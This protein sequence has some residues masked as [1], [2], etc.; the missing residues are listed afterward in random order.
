MPTLTYF[1]DEKITFPDK[2]VSVVEKKFKGKVHKAELDKSEVK[3]GAVK[4]QQAAQQRI[5]KQ[6]I[7][8][9]GFTSD[10][11]KQ[12]KSGGE[13]DGKLTKAG[14][15]DFFFNVNGKR[16]KATLE[17]ILPEAE[18]EKKP[19]YKFANTKLKSM[20]DKNIITKIESIAVVGPKETG[21]GPVEYLGGAFH[22]H[23][24]NT[25]GIAWE[26]K[27]GE[28][29]IVAIGK[30]NNQN[31][32]QQRGGTGKKLKTCQYDWTEK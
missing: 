6:I 17:L 9:L 2:D 3:D 26:W 23:V 19:E 32:E 30:K 4:S 16:N 24:T 31:K 5:F 11:V 15:Y 25:I 27:N 21:H 14:D 29:Y 7:E 1:L 8:H 22:A 12:L 20:A 10:G 28:M 18:E 13:F